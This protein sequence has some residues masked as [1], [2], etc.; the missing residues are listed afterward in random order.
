VLID[1]ISPESVVDVG[2]GVGAWLAAFRDAGVDDVLGLDGDYVPR[3]LLQ[4]EPDRFLAAN[5]QEPPDLNRRFDLAISLEVAEHLPES[6]SDR[7][8]ETLCKLAPVVLF[9]AATPLQGGTGHV[10]EQPQSYWAEK[11]ALHG[12]RAVDAVRPA[13]WNDAAV[14][15]W[16]RQNAVVYASPEALESNNRLREI[17]ERTDTRILDVI[18]PELLKHR[19][20]KPQI[21][22]REFLPLWCRRKASAVKQ[23][24]PGNR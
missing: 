6:A 17:A 4:I 3:D 15:F 20:A 8:V 16:Y 23:A 2:C 7:L 10:N 1:L 11:F 9:S 19:N 14:K 24:L 12:R 21:T 5:L 22:M 13:V 18:H